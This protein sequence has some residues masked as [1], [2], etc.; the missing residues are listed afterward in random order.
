MI[1]DIEVMQESS[2]NIAI[3]TYSKKISMFRHVIVLLLLNML[4]GSVV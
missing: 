3:T 4:Q 2:S 1:E